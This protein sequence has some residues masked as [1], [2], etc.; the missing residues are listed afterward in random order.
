MQANGNHHQTFQVLIIDDNAPDATL[1]RLAWSACKSVSVETSTLDDSRDAIKFLRA[2][3]PYQGTVVPDLIM[4]DYK[5]PVDGGIALTEI[6]GDP[7]YMHLPIIVL[8]GSTYGRDYLDAYRRGANCCFRKPSDL[9]NYRKLV[10]DIAEHW[11]TKAILPR[12]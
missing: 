11:L 1:L 2:A 6:K 5:M 9:E 10:C 12:P 7:E 8:S 4:L 3:D